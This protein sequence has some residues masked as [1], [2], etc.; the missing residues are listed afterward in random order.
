[1]WKQSLSEFMGFNSYFLS[2]WYLIYFRELYFSV[3]QI[4]TCVRNHVEPEA[5]KNERVAL[6]W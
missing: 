5:L 1:M 6:C 4:L 3:L 2:G